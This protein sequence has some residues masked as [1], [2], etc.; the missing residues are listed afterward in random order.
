MTASSDHINQATNWCVIPNAHH[1][2]MHPIR[3]A[4]MYMDDLCNGYGRPGQEHI[5]Q[6]LSKSCVLCI[7]GGSYSDARSIPS[8]QNTPATPDLAPPTS[9]TNTATIYSSTAFYVFNL[10]GHHPTRL[11]SHRFARR[12]RQNGGQ[13]S[14]RCP[15]MHPQA[16]VLSATH[17]HSAHSDTPGHTSA[18]PA[19]AGAP[20]AAPAPPLSRQRGHPCR[21]G[22]RPTC[23]RW[24]RAASP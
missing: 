7:T 12:H 1:G 6:Q 14:A 21:P 22:S 11:S 2:W 4:P 13:A 5:A 24:A 15:Q 19:A 17:P 10:A 9:S 3:K 8:S 20:H 18:A 23:P 16:A